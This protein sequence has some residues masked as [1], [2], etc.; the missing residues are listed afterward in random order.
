MWSM[1]SSPTITFFMASF[2]IRGVPLI[3]AYSNSNV[4]IETRDP[5]RTSRR[6]SV[7]VN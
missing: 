6:G 3:V 1:E 4:N 7:G 2:L 5:S